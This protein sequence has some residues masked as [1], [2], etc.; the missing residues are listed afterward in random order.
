MLNA[1]FR[2]R[3]EK[4]LKHKKSILGV[5]ISVFENV[6]EFV[7]DIQDFSRETKRALS[8][9]E[10]R[11]CEISPKINENVFF[12]G[13][14]KISKRSRVAVRGGFQRWQPSMKS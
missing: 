2:V 6:S 9:R 4:I 10:I 5:E 3:K 14:R 1:Q 13:F 12:Q 7:S 8:R 11:F